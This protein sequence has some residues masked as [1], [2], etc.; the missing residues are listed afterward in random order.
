M[1]LVLASSIPGR[2]RLRAA[3]LRHEPVLSR[4]CEVLQAHPG[5]V[6]VQ[7][8]ARAGSLLLHYDPALLPWRQAENRL[9][10]VAWAAVAPQDAQTP[11]ASETSEAPKAPKAPR[12]TRSAAAA[13]PS[14]A[15]ASVPAA[16]AAPAAP[17]SAQERHRAICHQANR[18]AKR[19]M[20]MSLGASLALAATGAKSGHAVLGGVFVL[21]LGVH[22]TVHRRHLLK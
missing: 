20:L 11:K 2:L 5:V 1:N 12:R 7:A 18:W 22:L 8:N 6:S 19:G 10:A 9:A 4:A 14:P 3:A 21:L 15:R 13:R 17:A 16:P